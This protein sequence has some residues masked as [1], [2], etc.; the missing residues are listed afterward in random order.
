MRPWSYE[1][2]QALSEEFTDYVLD[3]FT[4]VHEVENAKSGNSQGGGTSTMP[5]MPDM[6]SDPMMDRLSDLSKVDDG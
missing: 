4:I 1:E 2:W 3:T 5:P 6:P